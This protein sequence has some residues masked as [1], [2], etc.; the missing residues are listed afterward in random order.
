M[1]GECLS[2]CVRCEGGR[3]VKLNFMN[4]W[5]CCAIIFFS[6]ESVCPLSIFGCG[7]KLH[8]AF[9]QW[10]F[11]SR[12]TYY[13]N[14]LKWHGPWIKH[15]FWDLTN[16]L[17][18][19]RNVCVTEIWLRSPSAFMPFSRNA[20]ALAF[21]FSLMRSLSICTS[22]GTVGKTNAFILPTH[23]FPQFLIFLVQQTFKSLFGEQVLCRFSIIWNG[24][25]RSDW[26][27]ESFLWECRKETNTHKKK[28]YPLSSWLW[29]TMHWPTQITA[30]KR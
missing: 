30:T 17:Q 24:E 10:S 11:P 8:S 15:Q 14:E 25:F 9:V 16:S 13:L 5:K 12:K 6:I 2:V 1:S 28:T 27:A 23:E 7:R 22:E 29:T 3:W 26:N 19:F 21:F 20:A 4:S 18:K